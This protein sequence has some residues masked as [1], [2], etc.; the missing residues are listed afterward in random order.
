MIAGIKKYNFLVHHSDYT[1]LLDSLRSAGVVHVV[2]KRQLDEMSPAASDM[3]SLRKIKDTIR[4]IN[5]IV[6]EA[7]PAGN[8]EDPGKVLEEFDSLTKEIEQA[9]HQIELL[10]S[11]KEKAIPWGSFDIEMIRKLPESGWKISFYSCPEKS[12]DKEWK[13]NHAV[14]IISQRRGRLFFAVIFKDEDLS[15]INAEEVNLPER[16]INAVREEQDDFTK[17]IERINSTIKARAPVWLTSLNKGMEDI[18]NKFEYSLAAEQADKYADNTLYVLEGWVPEEEQKKVE[19][20]LEKADCYAFT[21]D[22]DPEEKIPVILK[23]GKFASLFEPISKLF[24]LPNYRELDLT[25]Y[26]AP[27][28][29]LFFGF[30]LGDA[31]YGL[32]FIIA[33]FIIKRK[34][35]KKF[36]PIITLGQYFGT[37]AVIMGLLSGTLFGINLINTGYTITGN[38][39]TQMKDMGVPVNTLSE[40]SMLRDQRFESRQSFSEEV[41]DKIGQENYSKYGKTIIRYAEPDLPLL[42][43][44]RHFMLDSLNMFYLALLLGALQIIF[45]MILR[46]INI[47]K[48]NG[49]KYSLSTIGWIVLIVTLVIF[50]GGGK[51]SIIDKEKLKPL[52][53][54][55]LGVSGI[56]IFFLNNPDKNIFIRF[57]MGIWDSYGIITGVFGDLLSYIRLFALGISSSILGFVFN[58]ISLQLLSVPFLGWLLFG[59]LLLVGHSL[60]IAIATLGSFVHPM[61][62]TFVEFYKNAGFTGGGI[63]YKPFKITK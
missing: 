56:M 29:M 26:F 4:R 48:L 13:E 39:I 40:L 6:P 43:S 21:T 27:F 3:K 38:S 35:D 61:R 60:N 15:D 22:P 16:D 24:A 10:K 28:F 49:F 59:I 34:I 1:R 47:S 32:V 7:V 2:E 42:S 58:Q 45:G 46:V 41:A 19:E 31:G 17:R 63:E 12:F 25:P 52:F 51:L 5:G 50:M 23:N 62:L 11:E 37:A 55:L 9:L 57:G 8:Y 36:R 20:L 44:F 18:I 53:F 54:G 30:C 33:G 14:E